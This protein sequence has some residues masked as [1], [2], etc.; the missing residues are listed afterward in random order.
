MCVCAISISKTHCHHD[1]WHDADQ[2]RCVRVCVHTSIHFYK[3][4]IRMEY[5]TFYG[6]I[7]HKNKSS[8]ICYAALLSLCAMATTIFLMKWKWSI[9]NAAIVLPF[10]FMHT[11]SLFL[12]IAMFV[13]NNSMTFQCDKLVGFI[14]C[15]VLHVNAFFW[16][17][18][19]SLRKNAWKLRKKLMR[20]IWWLKFKC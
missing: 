4:T 19:E 1:L 2:N 10:L 14:N 5:K 12:W 16:W 11:L 13:A 20:I 18:R 6:K 3:I 15:G 17:S 8:L 7:H 9:S